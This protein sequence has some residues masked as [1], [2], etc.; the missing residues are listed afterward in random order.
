M[1]KK[2]M[3]IASLVLNIMLLS[4]MPV[5]AQDSYKRVLFACGS[6][7]HGEVVWGAGFLAGNPPYLFG[8][9][10]YHALLESSTFALAGTA[11]V[12]DA[13]DSWYLFK[14]GT[15]KVAGAM[16]AQ[17]T[18]IDGK[19]HDLIILFKSTKETRGIVGHLWSPP[20]PGVPKWGD[21]CILGVGIPEI[22]LQVPL[23]EPEDM[24][25]NSA[26]LAFCGIHTYGDVKEKISGVAHLI[27]YD[28]TDMKIRE[29]LLNLW[30]DEP[31]TYVALVWLSYETISL[32]EWFGPGPEILL[33]AKVLEVHIK[34]I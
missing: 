7:G 6:N 31:G 13:V 32:E 27:I 17:W 10:E 28:W 30:I 12:E 33:P 15:A 8:E 11:Q 20:T 18:G 25:P 16:R 19:R 21:V 26:T 5:M 23:P 14:E 22:A 24:D 4:T 2:S 3:V 1:Y 9:P 29:F 34:L